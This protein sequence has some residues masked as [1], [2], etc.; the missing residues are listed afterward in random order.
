MMEQQ[1]KA[2]QDD[3]DTVIAYSVDDVRKWYVEDEKVI[4]N[5]DF[6]PDNWTELDPAAD[7]TILWSEGDT[8]LAKPEAANV[9]PYEGTVFNYE[10]T[11]S[12]MLWI[13]ANPRRGTLCS[14]EW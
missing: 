6:D 9:K 2:F 8:C 11:A 1:L 3:Y 13:A 7:L 5:S 14:T 12:V 10:V 4:D